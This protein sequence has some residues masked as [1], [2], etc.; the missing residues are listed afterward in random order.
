MYLDAP[1]LTALW[2]ESLLARQVLRGAT[3]GYRHHPQLTRFQA[4]S[5]PLVAIDAYLSAVYAEAAARGYRFDASKLQRPA[6]CPAMP[7]TL[8]QVEYEFDCLRERLRRRNRQRYEELIG[9]NCPDVHPIFYVVQ[10]GI[11]E[12]ERVPS[13]TV[14]GRANRK[15][16]R[17]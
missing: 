14:G 13:S 15:A 10:G 16:K 9:I 3:R 17:S 1:G 12:W 6:P 7:V 5:E 8:G 2:R 11:E 4:Q